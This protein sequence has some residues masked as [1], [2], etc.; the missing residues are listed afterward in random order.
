MLVWFNKSAIE[1][2]EKM[3]TAQ[4]RVDK[5]NAIIDTLLDAQLEFTA[6]PNKKEYKLDDGQTK[7]SVMYR[8]LDAVAA[9]ITHWERVKQMYLNRING[10]MVR[11][12]DGKNF[13]NWN[14]GTIC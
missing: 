5:V 8:D 14:L 6:D 2:P 11:L 4:A 9:S 12:L 1:K 7:I 3:T 10:R 13:P